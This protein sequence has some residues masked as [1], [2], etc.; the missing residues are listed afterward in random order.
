MGLLDPICC[1]MWSV[2]PYDHCDFR[3]VY[4]CTRVQGR[5]EVP[6]PTPAV[7][8]AFRTDKPHTC[9]SGTGPPAPSLTVMLPRSEEPE[10]VQPLGRRGDRLRRLF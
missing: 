10:A 5:S 9:V 8:D 7:L 3:C 6:G 1:G 4:C 2:T